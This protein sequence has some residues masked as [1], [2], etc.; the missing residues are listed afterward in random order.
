MMQSPRLAGWR[1][2]KGKVAIGR[3]GLPVKG[4]WEPVLDQATFDAVG[5]ALSPTEG[6]S[7]VLRKNARHYL[8]TGALRCGV[9][10]SV[11]YGNAAKYAAYRCSDAGHVV[12]ASV[13]PVDHLVTRV[14]LAKLADVAVKTPAME[15]LGGARL[16]EVEA[17]IARLMASFTARELSAEVVFPAV[18]QLEGERDQLRAQRRRAEAAEVA[19]D[20][21]RVDRTAWDSM[22]V[23]QRRAVIETLLSAVLVRPASRRGNQFDPERIEFVWQNASAT[24]TS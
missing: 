8:L 18:A 11:M 2:H 16:A 20:L 3:D 7:R 24:A 19:P 14:V 12:A 15:F 9:C 5:A 1:T 21:T 23:A 4:Q 17:A 13:A 6:R 10:G 22:E